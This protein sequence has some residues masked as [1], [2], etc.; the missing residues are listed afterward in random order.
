MVVSAVLIV[1]LVR[2]VDTPGMD[3]LV[4][5]NLQWAKF[6][7]YTAA[8]IVLVFSVIQTFTSGES[9]KKSLI[10]L[11]I[12]AVVFIVSNSMASS[13]LPQFFGVDKLVREGILTPWWTKATDTLL[14]G[15]YILFF[16]AVGS[17]VYSSISRIWK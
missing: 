4:D 14:Y 12:I 13:E 1:M 10:S 3:S 6:L 11:A 16:G 9:A 8:L 2:S 17:I 15:T 5:T 7:F